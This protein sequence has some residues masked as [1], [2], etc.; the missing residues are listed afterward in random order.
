MVVFDLF[1]QV[2]AG[3]KLGRVPN[4]SNGWRRTYSGGFLQ[5]EFCRPRVGSIIR[6]QHSGSTS[7]VVLGCLGWLP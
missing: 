7:E 1:R 5:F 2:H 6:F 4:D 3:S